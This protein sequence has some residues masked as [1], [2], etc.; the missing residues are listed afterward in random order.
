MGLVSQCTGDGRRDTVWSLPFPGWPQ[1]GDVATGR[2]LCLPLP[3][4]STLSVQHPFFSPSKGHLSLRGRERP[5]SSEHTLSFDVQLSQLGQDS[6]SPSFP[7]PLPQGRLPLPA[8]LLPALFIWLSP[9][10]LLRLPS[11]CICPALPLSQPG[12]RNLHLCPALDLNGGYQ[13]ALALWSPRAPQGLNLSLTKTPTGSLTPSSHCFVLMRVLRVCMC[14]CSISWPPT[15]ETLK[16]RA[17]IPLPL[18]QA[19]TV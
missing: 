2:R 19:P 13:H 5:A 15:R 8:S 18:S 1:G 7:F 10:S 11:L 4:S 16:V 17:W 14:V 3:P 6:S 9:R 12:A